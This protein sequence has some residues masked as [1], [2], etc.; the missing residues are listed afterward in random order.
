M[1]HHRNQDHVSESSDWS[2]AVKSPEKGSQQKTK[3]YSLYL[4]I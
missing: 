2:N 1:W 3:F 4:V